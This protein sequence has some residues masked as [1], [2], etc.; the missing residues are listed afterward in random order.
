MNITSN[1]NRWQFLV[2]ILLI[3]IFINSNG[4]SQKKKPTRTNNVPQDTTLTIQEKPQKTQSHTTP[5]VLKY[6]WQL[7]F[8]S[9]L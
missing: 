8:K 5:T 6:Y 9:L 4:L 7:L 3:F 1:K 2:S